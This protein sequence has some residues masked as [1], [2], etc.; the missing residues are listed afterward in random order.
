MDWIVNLL[1]KITFQ[2]ALLFLGSVLVV[3]S[4][5]EKIPIKDSESPIS[6]PC[7]LLIVGL[8]LVVMAIILFIIEKWH[9]YKDITKFSILKENSRLSF[10][11]LSISFRFEDIQMIDNSTTTCG[12]VLPISTDPFDDCITSTS[13][14]VGS[15]FAHRHLN[16]IEKTKEIIQKTVNG[17]NGS[18]NILEKGSVIVLPD[19]FNIP[20]KTMLTVSSEH[21][22]KHKTDPST[23]FKSVENIFKEAANHGISHIYLPVIGSGYGG[24]NLTDAFNLIIM[25]LKF[26]SQ[27]YTK[28]RNITICIRAKEVSDINSTFLN[29]YL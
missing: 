5:L 15:F 3:L 6:S 7:V 19:E 9:H 18:K 21:T 29:S 10:N 20:G 22:N 13:T 11:N 24:M 16:R 12:F 14:A 17:Q 2:V 26:L 8:F 28:R 4:C 27:E 23:I 25:H 1:T